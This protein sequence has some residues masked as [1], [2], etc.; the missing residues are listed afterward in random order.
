M[1]RFRVVVAVVCTI[2][3]LSLVLIPFTNADWILFRSDTSHSGEG[4]GNP[5]LAPTLLW[6]Y[7]TV[8]PVD[9]SPAVVGGVVYV[10]SDDGNVYALNAASG[11][12]LWNYTTGG[13]VDSSPAVVNGVVYVGSLDGNVYALGGYPTLTVSISPTSATLDIGQSKMFSATPNGGSGTYTSYQ[14][15]V[16]GS[17]QSSQTASTFSF[18]PASA[19][20]YS[21]TAT[22][23]DSSDTTSAKSQA[24]T[25][26]VNSALVA[27]TASASLG[28]VDRGQTSSLTLPSVT[29]GTSPY[30]YQWIE[31]GPSD[32]SF[33]NITGATLASYSFVTS[34]STATGTWLFEVQVTD[35]A[36]TP[37]VV[38]STAASVTVNVAPTVS[39]APVGPLTLTVGEVQAFTATTSGGS[40]TLSYQWYLDGAAVGTNSAS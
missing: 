31:T 37:V 39:I 34:S 4:T 12:Q 19:G 18:A 13:P 32:S 22:V 23:N 30:T 2:F 38:T 27:S 11:I 24:A 8:G 7:T 1:Y 17:A 26:T 21:I 25:V 14:W 28:T 10:G 20:S 33:S 29:T 3:L 35:S 6:N 16:D 9:S 36:S 15:Y 5:A 40:G